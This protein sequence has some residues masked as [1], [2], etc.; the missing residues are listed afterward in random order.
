VLYAN[1]LSKDDF[2]A[3]INPPTEIDDPEDAKPSD[4]IDSPKMANPLASKPGEELGLTRTRALDITRVD[5][6]WNADMTGRGTPPTGDPHRQEGPTE[7]SP[8]KGRGTQGTHT[9]HTQTFSF[10]FFYSD[11]WDDDAP[12]NLGP[13][14]VKTTTRNGYDAQGGNP[15]FLVLFLLLE[16]C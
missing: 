16:R 15:I 8:R 2:R 9:E 5:A 6:T 3:P 11:D 13:K 12:V 14:G 7:D 10:L 4:W 1:L